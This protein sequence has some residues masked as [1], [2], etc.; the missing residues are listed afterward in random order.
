[1]SLGILDI[2]V[3]MARI[4]SQVLL[5]VAVAGGL[6]VWLMMRRAMQTPEPLQIAARYRSRIV[7]IQGARQPAPSRVVALLSFDDLMRIADQKGEPILYFRRDDAHYYFVYATD[8]I[9]RVKIE[10]DPEHRDLMIDADA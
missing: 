9:Y 2:E 3:G 5:F 1:V 7:P 8:V 10:S 4:A 6:L